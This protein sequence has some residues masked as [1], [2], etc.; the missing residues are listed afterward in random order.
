MDLVIER[1][2]VYLVSLDPTVGSEIRKARPCVVVSPNSINKNLSNI[3][4]VPLTS[5]LRSWPTRVDVTFDVR[6]GQF[7]TEQLRAV[8]KQRIKKKLGSIDKKTGSKLL[9]KLSE[10]FAE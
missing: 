3:I 10:I 5:S 1:F 2:S 4:I 7:I 9:K 8:S 6:K